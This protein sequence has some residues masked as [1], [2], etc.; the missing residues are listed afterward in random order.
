MWGWRTI[1]YLALMLLAIVL[2]VNR[3]QSESITPDWQEPVS[4]R[5]YP[6]NADQTI[7]T[8]EY[9]ATLS[10]NDFNDI[11]QFFV[12]ESKRYGL[13]LEKPLS[14]EFYPVVT[15]L[16]PEAPESASILDSLWWGLRMRLWVAGNDEFDADDNT[17]RVFMN[18]YSP[19]INSTM[20]HSLGLQKGRIGLVNGFA[21]DRFQGLN[22]FV[23]VHEALHTLGALD[24]YDPETAEPIW[25]DG[26]ADPVQVPL[27]PQT[28]AE[29]MGGRIP[30][31][32][33]VAVLPSD[34]SFA[35][36]GPATAI[37]IGWLD[38]VAEQ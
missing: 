27:Y 2:W 8:A 9:L 7:T 24:R 12:D 30:L 10:D 37:E 15:S 19:S 16:P 4:L 22:H 23:A 25:P 3:L 35:R 31:V 21:S 13:P 18:Y 5:I 33:G 28:R 17:I 11:E 14:V 6:V 26:F 38:P 20:K 34:L 36:I 29:V 1:S 32:P